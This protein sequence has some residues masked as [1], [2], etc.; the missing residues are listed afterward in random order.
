MLLKSIFEKIA[1]LVKYR[2][3]NA[4]FYDN[5]AVD[6]FTRDIKIAGLAGL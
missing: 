6:L 4:K 1:T 3:M 2:S 5:I